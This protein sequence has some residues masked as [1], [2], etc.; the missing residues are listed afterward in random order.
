MCYISVSYDSS[1]SKI[2]DNVMIRA[3]AKMIP[4]VEIGQDS[5]VGA[6]AVVIEDVPQYSTV[7]LQRPRVINNN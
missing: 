3:G 1:W 7:V 4:G 5:K 2:G 6:N